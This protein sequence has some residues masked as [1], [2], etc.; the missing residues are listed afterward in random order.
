LW[1]SIYV[2]KSK[3]RKTFFCSFKTD[4]SFASKSDVGNYTFFF[5]TIEGHSLKLKVIQGL[6]INFFCRKRHESWPLLLNKML[7]LGDKCV[8]INIYLDSQWGLLILC[9]NAN[10]KHSSLLEN[11]L[12]LS[13]QTK[14]Q[15]SPWYLFASNIRS[16]NA[17]FQLSSFKTSPARATNVS[18]MTS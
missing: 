2:W 12:Y 17:K 18:T 8:A 5:S 7:I 4:S 1:H 3:N 11:P 13:P 10:N 16:L 14:F 15:K 9:E 6:K